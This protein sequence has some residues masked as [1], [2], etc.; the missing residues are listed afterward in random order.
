M[1]VAPPPA[2]VVV[3]VAAAQGG[4][5]RQRRVRVTVGPG[6]GAGV[7]GAGRA[8]VG[9]V[10]AA[11]GCLAGPEVD[12]KESPDI[13]L[14]FFSR[15]TPA[16]RPTS[17]R[18]RERR[19]SP[20]PTQPAH[21]THARG[22]PFPRARVSC[23]LPQSGPRPRA[24]HFAPVWAR[25]AAPRTWRRRHHPHRRRRR[26][27]RELR[28]PRRS[29]WPSW[30][31]FRPWARGR[32]VFFFFFFF[33]A[34]R[35]AGVCPRAPV[36]ALPGVFLASGVR[37]GGGADVWVVPWAVS[38]GVAWGGRAWSPALHTHKNA[39]KLRARG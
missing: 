4:D 34:R 6:M 31:G 33:F 8:G 22:V 28:G 35:G 18:S 3:G 15:H 17:P 19:P 12:K 16:T 26:S 1:L 36:W 2:S 23:A 39:P 10:G 13:D 30:T 7:G 24:P 38:E 21:S 20:P 9:G 25:V 37:A 14:F 27:R 5:G 29:T 11:V 32:W